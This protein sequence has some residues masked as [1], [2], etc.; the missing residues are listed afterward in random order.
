MYGCILLSRITGIIVSRFAA[1]GFAVALRSA[2]YTT[3]GTHSVEPP[4]HRSIG[5]P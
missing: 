2:R 5:T 4:D 3:Y 1:V